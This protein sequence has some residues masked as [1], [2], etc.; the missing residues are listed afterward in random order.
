M[1][2]PSG[3]YRK[4]PLQA[5]TAARVRVWMYFDTLRGQPVDRARQGGEVRRRAQRGRTHYC[6]GWALAGGV[7][8]EQRTTRQHPREQ[9]RPA[10][11]VAPGH[12]R[13]HSVWLASAR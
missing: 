11:E 9:A 4:M 7:G 12:R 1:L 2:S 3:S 5:D 8:G 10:Q 13:V 6:P